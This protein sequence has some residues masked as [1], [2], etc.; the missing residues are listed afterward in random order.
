M[1]S[2]GPLGRAVLPEHGLGRKNVADKKVYG[3]TL[4]YIYPRGTLS[5]ENR[6]R[7]EYIEIIGYNKYRDNIFGVRV[8]VTVR[9]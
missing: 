9:D 8:R 6:M 1:V 7:I 5:T 4:A 2:I 3:Q